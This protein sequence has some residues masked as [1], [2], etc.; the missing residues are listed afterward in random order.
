MR[1]LLALTLLSVMPV[2]AWSGDW[3]RATPETVGLA[4]EPLLALDSEFVAGKVPLVDSFLVLRCGKV[5]FE[6]YYT[7]DYRTIYQKEAHERGPLNAHLSGPYNY[8][9]PTWHPYYQGT[10]E[11]TMQSV[12]KSITSATIGVAIA[13]GDF[14]A[15]LETPVLHYFDVKSVGNVDDK[16]RHMTLRHVLTMTTGFDW[17]EDVPYADPRNTVN[18]MEASRDWVKFV[19]DRPMAHEPGSTFAYNS[20]ATELLAYI[21]KKETGQDIEGYARRYLFKPLGIQH[22]HWKRSPLGVA[23]TEGGV[24]LN[25]EDLAK[26]GY[27]YMHDGV[28]DAHRLLKSEWIMDS[29]KA[30]VDAG[31]G[32]KYGYQWWLA[33]YGGGPRY[34]WAGRGFGGQ[35]LW[36]F[37]DEDL[38][39]VITAWRTLDATPYT[40][41]VLEKFRP[42]V[43]DFRCEA[44]TGRV[45][46]SS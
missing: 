15:P 46:G 27:L 21:F 32:W 11:H 16:K 23:D 14:R 38:V 42:A 8:F 39:V 24:Y 34:A 9:D 40:L 6:R 19:I 33:P 31:G 30:H 29:M 18:L 20:G 1:S 5:A 36:M 7:H 4:S 28:W 43:R 10:D 12:S 26:I 17:N 25:S 45:E 3:P 44:A 13:R 37:P 41:A 2:A 22:Y 35:Y